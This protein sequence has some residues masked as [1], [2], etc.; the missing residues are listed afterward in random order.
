MG[1]ADLARL[2]AGRHFDLELLAR[3]LLRN[4]TSAP[5]RSALRK[6]LDDIRKLRELLNAETA[7]EEACGDQRPV[8]PDTETAP[9]APLDA[10]PCGDPPEPRDPTPYRDD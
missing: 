1:S 9:L 4:P 5:S 2:I 7:V 8:P 6:C 3:T 10:A